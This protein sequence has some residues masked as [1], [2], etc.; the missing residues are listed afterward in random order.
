MQSSDSNIEGMCDCVEGRLRGG[1]GAE[2]WRSASSE[3]RTSWSLSQRDPDFILIRRGS[4]RFLIS[5]IW[6]Q[7]GPRCTDSE[8]EG[9]FFSSQQGCATRWSL[10]AGLRR[11][12]ER[13]RKWRGN[14]ER[15]RK[16]RGNG[17]RMRKWRERFTLKISSFSVYFLPTY[18]FP[19]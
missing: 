10:R 3:G 19:I 1:G 2:S 18:P 8:T 4:R 7:K 11:N 12:G 15:M 17:E 5:F 14:G 16:W 9:I 6:G 13:M